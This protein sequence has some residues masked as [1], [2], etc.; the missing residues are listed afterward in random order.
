[1]KK[2]GKVE[3]PLS[4]QRL[5]NSQSHGVTPL[6]IIEMMIKRR[7]LLMGEAITPERLLNPPTLQ[8]TINNTTKTRKTTIGKEIANNYQAKDK[9]RDQKKDTKN[10]RSCSHSKDQQG[11]SRSDSRDKKERSQ[12][13]DTLGKMKKD[14]GY[15]G[16]KYGNGSKNYDD[17]REKNSDRRNPHSNDLQIE[18]PKFYKQR[19]IK[20]NKTEDN[21]P[22][23]V[24]EEKPANI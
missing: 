9:Y 3:M 10:S 1:M 19:N 11:N 23:K 6:K 17:N 24:Q 13:G 4:L 12:N 18:K 21:F 16:R 15:T 7:N 22:S 5:I 20:Y 2:R 8:R 14:Y